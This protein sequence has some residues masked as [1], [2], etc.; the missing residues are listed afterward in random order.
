MEIVQGIAGVIALGIFA[1]LLGFD[2][3]N[4]VGPRSRADDLSWMDDDPNSTLGV[5][6][7]VLADKL[8]QHPPEPLS[9]SQNWSRA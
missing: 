4:L 9:Y 3:R 1:A 7:E 2:V 5:T 6:R 8:E